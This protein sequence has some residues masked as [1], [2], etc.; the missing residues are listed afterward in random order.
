MN[1]NMIA[2]RL[3][4]AIE[5]LEKLNHGSYGEVAKVKKDGEVY[6]MK[7]QKL[8]SINPIEREF[9]VQKSLEG[10]AGIPKAVKLYKGAFMMDYIDGDLL[11]E[12]GKQDKRFFHELRD[13]VDGIVSRNYYLGRDFGATN[14]MVDRQGKPWVIDFFLYM[15]SPP[16]MDSFFYAMNPRTFSPYDDAEI[17][18]S[19]LE[20]AFML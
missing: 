17:K 18:L 14:L 1:L 15:E 3:D 4:P 12:V 20:K 9:H 2:K 11:C 19:Y 8:A 5:V 10:I 7:F 6:A 13:I 16:V